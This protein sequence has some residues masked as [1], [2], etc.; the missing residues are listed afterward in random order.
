MCK[1]CHGAIDG[2]HVAP[3]DFATLLAIGAFQGVLD[4]FDGTLYRQEL[5]DREKAHLHHR[6]DAP[7]QARA[8]GDRVGIH[9]VNGQGL[10][11]DVSLDLGAQVSEDLVC[12]K[13]GVEQ[14]RAA[15]FDAFDHIHAVQQVELMAGDQVGRLDQIGR[16]QAAVGKA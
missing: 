6:I 8:H 3:H 1:A 12:R 9:R 14:E 10:I 4:V 16:A 2:Q 11:D 15:R 7:A 13:G 5:R